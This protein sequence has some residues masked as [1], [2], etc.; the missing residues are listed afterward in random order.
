MNDSLD[1][2]QLNAFVLPANTGSF[3]KTVK[4]LCVTHSAISH[5][6]RNLKAQVGCRLLSKLG[7]TVMLTEAGETLFHHADSN[8]EAHL[9]PSYS[10]VA[11]RA[12]MG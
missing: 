2:R 6:L 1:S 7:K 5:C 12:I 4:P 8:Q 9:Q 11:N 3:A 10:Q